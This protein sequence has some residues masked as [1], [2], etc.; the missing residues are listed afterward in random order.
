MRLAC[1]PAEHDR[2]GSS[3]GHVDNISFATC[4]WS[5]VVEDPGDVHSWQVW[6]DV[7][8]LYRLRWKR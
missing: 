2:I 8:S 7:L 1:A 4:A 5:R 6:L 3:V